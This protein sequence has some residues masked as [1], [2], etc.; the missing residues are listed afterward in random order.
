MQLQ[1]QNNG[2][3]TRWMDPIKFEKKKTMF[4]KT[5]NCLHNKISL[6]T[7]LLGSLSFIKQT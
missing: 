1:R 7:H 6:G 4:N 5:G 3:I 2:N